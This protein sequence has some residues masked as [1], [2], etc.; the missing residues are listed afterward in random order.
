MDCIQAF[1]ASMVELVAIRLERLVV[2]LNGASDDRFGFDRAIPASED[3][4]R[5][6][7]GPFKPLALTS[8]RRPC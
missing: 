2:E 8:N 6:A 1:Q 7:A 4:R 5:P 3:D